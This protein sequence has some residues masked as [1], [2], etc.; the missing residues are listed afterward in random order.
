MQ[1]RESRWSFVLNTLDGTVDSPA[2]PATGSSPASRNTAGQSD[3]SDCSVVLQEEDGHDRGFLWIGVDESTIHLVAME[4]AVGPRGCTSLFR[5]CRALAVAYGSLCAFETMRLG[6][7]TMVGDEGYSDEDSAMIA[8]DKAVAVR[9]QFPA[10]RVIS[11][12]TGHSLGVCDVPHLTF[13]S[14]GHRVPT[15]GPRCPRFIQRWRDLGSEMPYSRYSSH[16]G[17]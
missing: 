14:R 17:S 9:D 13:H 4:K 3:R 16:S 6:C 5:D 2:D 12:V 11:S 1:R 8:N 7:A 15:S 10:K